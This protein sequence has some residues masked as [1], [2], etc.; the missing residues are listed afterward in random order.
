MYYYQFV[1]RDVLIAVCDFIYIYS[2]SILW[3][4]TYC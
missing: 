2:V 3:Q 4:D 1:V